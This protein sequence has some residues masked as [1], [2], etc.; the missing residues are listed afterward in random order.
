LNDKT[1]LFA[2]RFAKRN[3]GK[4]PSMSQAGHSATL[5]YL[6]AVAKSGNPQDGAAVVPACVRP[7]C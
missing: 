2:E 4:M 1:R 5:V 7:A 6:T 3:A